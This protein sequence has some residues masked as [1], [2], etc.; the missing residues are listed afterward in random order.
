VDVARSVEIRATSGRLVVLVQ[1]MPRPKATVLLT[2]A[3]ISTS[4]NGKLPLGEKSE[5]RLD[6]LDRYRVTHG[7]EAAGEGL[8]LGGPDIGLGVVLADQEG[9]SDV[10]R[11]AQRDP[12]CASANQELTCPG[13]ESSAPPHHDARALEGI[14]RA[15][16]V[17]SRRHRLPLFGSSA[18]LMGVS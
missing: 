2:V 14:D 17:A 8:G 16:V 18:P 1:I 15:S 9:A 7:R 6:D 3:S 4:Q 12:G 10:G 5:R 13:P 11:I